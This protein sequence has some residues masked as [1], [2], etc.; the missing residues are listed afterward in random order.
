MIT[1]AGGCVQLNKV[2]WLVTPKC[3]PRAVECHPPH[4]SVEEV[5]IMSRK[6]WWFSYC[7]YTSYDSWM[8]C[9]T[10][11]FITEV[12]YLIW[13]QTARW[14]ER[15]MTGIIS[16]VEVQYD[17]KYCRWNNKFWFRE[18]CQPA[19]CMTKTCWVPHG[20]NKTVK[21]L[22]GRDVCKTTVVITPLQPTHNVTFKHPH[23]HSIWQEMWQAQ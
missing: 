9:L 17:C 18:K 2:L 20:A 3:R 15:E 10:S 19:V 16:H 5:L 22:C 21:I 6:D 8:Y 1:E 13:P 4:S 11:C 7:C 14:L 23:W 12:S